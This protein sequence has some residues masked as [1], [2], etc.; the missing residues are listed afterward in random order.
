MVAYLALRLGA[1]DPSYFRDIRPLLQRQCQGCHQP[2]LKSSDLDLTSYEGL[3]AG[4]KHGPALT[5][6]V[7]Y[8]TGELRPQM[9][10]NQSP[11]PAEQIDLVRAWV[12]AGGKNDTPA[13]AGAI[14][15]AGP[16]VYSLPP[17]TTALAFS[18][19]GKWLAVSG[20][21][22]ILVHPVDG[23]GP[24]KRLPGRSE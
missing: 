11:L 20:N 8:L 6:I 12:A 14:A 22:E 17:V 4:G 21:R 9:P 7:K 15:P 13:E 19:D 3:A 24:P 2:E 16:T 5:L 1:A 10:L 18:P 23:N